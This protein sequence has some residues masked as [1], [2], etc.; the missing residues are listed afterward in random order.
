MYITVSELYQ[1]CLVLIGLATLIV[2]I[3]A[4]KKE[5]IRLP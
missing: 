1:F 5:I 3:F 2:A 4:Q